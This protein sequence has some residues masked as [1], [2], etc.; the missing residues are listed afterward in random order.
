MDRPERTKEVRE[1]GEKRNDE[2][3]EGRLKTRKGKLE[4]QQN[5]GEGDEGEKETKK[6]IGKEAKERGGTMLYATIN[7]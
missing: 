1:R 7:T 2:R 3:E 6:E 5:G 4:E